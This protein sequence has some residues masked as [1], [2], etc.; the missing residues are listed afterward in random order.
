M[1]TVSM[2]IIKRIGVIS[3]SGEK[4]T[5]E[6]NLISWGGKEPVYDL[7]KWSNGKAYRGITLSLDECAEL[8]RLLSEMLTDG[9]GRDS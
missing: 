4:T 3:Q 7:R 8:S 6:L 1:A 9:K 5:K 2:E